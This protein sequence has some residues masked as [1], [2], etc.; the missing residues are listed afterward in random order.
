MGLAVPDFSNPFFSGIAQVIE[1]R[2]RQLGY[3]LLMADT[4]E[5]PAT[6]LS[7]LQRMSE[8]VDG[9]IAVAPRA[10][11]EDLHGVL[12]GM[13]NVVLINRQLPGLAS[14]NVDVALGMRQAVAHLAALGHRDLGYI[15]GPEASRAGRTIAASLRAAATEFGCQLSELA[16]VEPNHRG[17]FAAADVVVASKVTAVVAHN[18]LIAFGL[19]SR[20]VE[21]GL[22]V[23]DD[24]SVIGC[25]D[26]PFSSM[27]TPTLT[28]V[29]VDPD[30]VGRSAVDL[31]MRSIHA[32]EDIGAV[33][34]TVPSQ[35]V[36]RASTGV[37]PV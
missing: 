25:D 23:P 2:A 18:D 15:G 32:G 14:V 17:G 13:E 36:V 16:H 21:R 10:G 37:A 9:V 31:L 22:A 29:A 28:S 8:Q 7:T 27:L 35:L 4:D 34:V 19:I 20:L 24:V 12:A 6:E 11:D 33:E 5:D 26:I 3:F 1:R 30:R